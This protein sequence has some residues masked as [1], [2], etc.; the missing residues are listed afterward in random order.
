MRPVH[1]LRV[2][3]RGSE[4]GNHLGVVHDVTGLDDERMQ[5]I[6]TDLGFSET[7]YLDWRQ[8]GVPHARIFTP[9]R[10]LP[11]SGHPLVGAAW[12]LMSHGPGT[13][14]RLTCEVGEIPFRIE[15]DVVWVDTPMVEDVR[16]ADDA[17]DRTAGAGLPTP[18]RAWWAN[19]PVT[20][21]I[22]EYDSPEPVEEAVPDAAGLEATGLDMCYLVHRSDEVAKVRFFAP[23]AG[24]LEDPATGSAAAALAAVLR[25]E[26]EDA[27]SIRLTQG[28]E[29]GRPC[30]IH[31]RWD[32]EHASLGGTV[33]HDEIREIEY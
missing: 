24:V 29:M 27:G 21:F 7:V 6:A 1:V 14:D 26:G 30:D 25:S 20:Y 8:T 23:T 17:A 22:A 12:S 2:F 33:V 13:V 16:P 31:L 3:T 18:D 5:G 9:A 10:E 28:D 11:F 4:G 32:A 15:G 19:M